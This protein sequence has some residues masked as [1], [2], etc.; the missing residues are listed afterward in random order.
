MR[1]ETSHLNLFS[2]GF[3]YCFPIIISMMRIKKAFL[4]LLVTIACHGLWA[5]SVDI[6]APFPSQIRVKP[7]GSSILIS[8]RDSKDIG[9]GSYVIYRHT[10]E[11]TS[12]NLDDAM[13]IAEV[14][15]GVQQYIDNPPDTQKYYY[16]I[17]G[18]DESA[19]LHDYFIAYRNK[20][21]RGYSA[22]SLYTARELAADISRI[23]AEKIDD[24][25]K[26]SFKA[27][28]P[29]RELIIYRSTTPLIKSSDIL[30]ATALTTFTSGKDYYLDYPVPG[31]NYY[32]AIY[33]S[34]LLAL[35]DIQ[36]ETGK[37]SLK[38]SVS[39]PITV[40]RTGVTS[41][42]TTRPK[43]L[44]MLDI[45]STI[46]SGDKIASGLNGGPEFTALSREALQAAQ[47][48]A[49]E[50]PRES[51]AMFPHIL[52]EDRLDYTSGEEYTLSNMIT[53]TIQTAKWGQAIEQFNKFL[54]I[55]HSPAIEARAHFYLGQAYYF[56]G[57]Y[58]KAF[59]EFLYARKLYHTE[60]SKWLN[61]V[62]YYL[63]E[64]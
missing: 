16:C 18:V 30:D 12:S 32:Y 36:L 23:S 19:K 2:Y 34:E 53:S 35:G 60:S 26:I 49:P 47:Q 54:S 57:E 14:G 22:E 58:R 52:D 64:Q 37:N 1:A 39:I 38:N 41:T 55:P 33:D 56:T 62:F 61:A 40:T 21:T 17:L 10:E 20:T 45:S 3:F 15:P 46:S 27:D 13:R 4:T 11:I 50:T 6:F 7:K 8:W 51:P 28:K 43:P 9:N 24:S 5:Q 25:I 48:I 59:V 29:D 31:I 42:I 44:P 63:R